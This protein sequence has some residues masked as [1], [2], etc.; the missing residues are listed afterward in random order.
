MLVA[1]AFRVDA[2]A[3]GPE[4]DRLKAPLCR[5][6]VPGRLDGLE[7]EPLGRSRDGAAIQGDP[8]GSAMPVIVMMTAHGR[9]DVM[10]RAESMGMD[11]FLMPPALPLLLNVLVDRVQDDKAI[12][13]HGGATMRTGPG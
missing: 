10:R 12:R 5:R 7:D 11:G 3:S 2:V 4:G 6:T 1:M 8:R 13:P 9:E